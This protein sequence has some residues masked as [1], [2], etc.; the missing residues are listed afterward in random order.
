MSF[1][2]RAT[3]PTDANGQR[4]RDPPRLVLGKLLEIGRLEK[5]VDGRVDRFGQRIPAAAQK[6][7]KE[8]E[9]TQHLDQACENKIK[10]CRSSWGSQSHLV[11]HHVVIRN[12]LNIRR[13]PPEK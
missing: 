7:R 4:T 12:F 8:A 5:C 10:E 13:R 1:P 3:T 9:Q 2:G 11:M 6:R